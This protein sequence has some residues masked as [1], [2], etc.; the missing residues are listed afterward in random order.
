MHHRCTTMNDESGMLPWGHK[1]RAE[2]FIEPLNDILKQNRW[3]IQ[4]GDKLNLEVMIKDI[5][6]LLED[7]ISKKEYYNEIYKI[8]NEETCNV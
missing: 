5:K 6:S 2:T 1:G 8:V 3:R 4:C 7:C